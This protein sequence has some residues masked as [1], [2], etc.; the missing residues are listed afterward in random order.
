MTLLTDGEIDTLLAESAGNVSYQSNYCRST[1]IVQNGRWTSKMYARKYLDE[2][3][4]AERKA[5]YVAPVRPEVSGVRSQP[6]QGPFP[7]GKHSH[8]CKG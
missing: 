5:L 2:L 4:D 8:R 7:R 3:L 6:Y 1:A